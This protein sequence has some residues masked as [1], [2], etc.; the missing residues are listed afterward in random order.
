LKVR[1]SEEMSF[2]TIDRSHC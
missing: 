2:V 1:Q